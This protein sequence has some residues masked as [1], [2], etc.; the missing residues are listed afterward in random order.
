[1]H[2]K[3]T[4]KEKYTALM[5]RYWEAGTTPDEERDLARYVA[6]VDD[7]DFEAL[8][9]VLGYLSLGRKQKQHRVRAYRLYSWAAAAAAL[10]VFVSV[11]LATRIGGHGTAR[12]LC[13]R[14]SYGE[15]TTDSEQIMASVDA[16]L[17]DFFAGDTPAETNLIEMFRR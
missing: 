9:G 14:Y 15:P 5:Q 11:G 17:S 3:M 13:I 10:V 2:W 4:D 7:P 6:G 8:R 1:M 12:D 16:S